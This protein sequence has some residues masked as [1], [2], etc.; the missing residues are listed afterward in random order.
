MEAEELQRRLKASSYPEVRQLRCFVVDGSRIVVTG[1][2]SSFYLKQ[3]A[4]ETLRN[5][6]LIDNQVEVSD[7]SQRKVG[8]L[9]P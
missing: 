1:Q 7:N 5:G 6:L 3:I 4:Q 2:V 9:S 8:D